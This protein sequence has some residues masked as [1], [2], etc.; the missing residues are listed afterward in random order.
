MLSTETKKKLMSENALHDKDTG[1]SDVQ[2]TV[3]TARIE[4][5][6]QHLKI[7][8]KDH[9]SRRGLLAMVSQ[10]RKLLSYL[11]GNDKDRYKKLIEKLKL[12]K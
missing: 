1:S 2:I 12:R 9:S 11:S 10:R 6:T 5:V 3:L 8:R 7:N 4:Q